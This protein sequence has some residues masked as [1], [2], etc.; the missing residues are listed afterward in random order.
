MRFVAVLGRALP[1]SASPRG[2]RAAADVVRT[3]ARRSPILALAALALVAVSACGP[4]PTPTM[5]AAPSIAGSAAPS[6][7]T[8]TASPTT[9]DSPTASATPLPSATPAPSGEPVMLP[10]GV[11]Y[12]D[13]ATRTVWGLP[14]TSSW[15]TVYP[16][17]RWSADGQVRIVLGARGKAIRA[18]VQD[19]PGQWRDVA[20]DPG[21]GIRL[22][23]PYTYIDWLSAR[24]V[25]AGPGGYLVLGEESVSD[26]Y[27]HYLTRIGFAWF[28]RDGAK[29]ARTDFRTVLGAGAAF[30]PHAVVPA[31][32]GWVVA[33]VLTS[34]DL[35][36]KAQIVVLT[37]A[38]GT[39]WRVASRLSDRWALSPASL[40][41]LGDRLV[42]AGYAWVCDATGFSVNDGIGS[43]ATRLWSSADGGRT[44]TKGDSTAGGVITLAK[45]APTSA[46]ACTGGIGAYRSLGGFYGVVNGRAVAVSAD[47]ARVATSTDLSQWQTASLAG[48][49]P[50]GEA[51]YQGSA[52]HA[53]VA[54]PNGSGLSIL[55]LE[56]RRDDQDR[57]GGF[58][59]QIFAWTSTDGVSWA[60]VPPSR[61]IET[62]PDATLIVSPDNSVYLTEERVTAQTCT[63][64]CI[65]TTDPRTYRRS[66]AGPEVAAPPCMPAAHADCS[67]S[68]LTSVPAGADLTGID[69]FGSELTGTV[70][71]SNA[72]LTG[73]RLI[74]VTVDAGASL[75]GTNL[76]GADL[77]SATIKDGAKLAGANLTNARLTSANVYA[78]DASNLNFTGADLSRANLDAVDLATATLNRAT[79]DGTSVNQSILSARLDGVARLKGL[80]VRIGGL[81]AGLAGRDFGALKLDGWYFSGPRVK[82]AGDLRGADFHRASLV[83]TGFSNVDLT[84]ARLPRG[85]R[86]QTDF[87]GGKTIYFG[88]DVICPDGKPGT[89]VSFSFDCRI[90]D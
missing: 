52:A 15:Y 25:A 7:A 79:I 89:K 6:T 45:P 83:N 87:S 54:A 39:H 27:H 40:S 4:A 3:A 24:G 88:N 23:G 60:A 13:A 70:D 8:G 51:S 46:K 81:G 22:P 33:G 47:H 17:Q 90:G 58:G 56:A 69:L 64:G 36:A 37:S 18:A 42:L 85:Y 75:V 55:S 71:L 10:A 80:L 72:N 44:W 34:R 77:T 73:A 11:Q 66:V 20:V 57:V 48:A 1:L 16:G 32:G 21:K 82:S 28:S 5:P 30:V 38:D 78:T 2:A 68:T 50:A 86:S 19:S 63:N 29:W 31:G 49:V 53:L 35:R 65:Y 59:S 14:A 9:T 41:V 76:T 26:P 74:G 61:P 84:G 12:T 67:F 62:S 43:A